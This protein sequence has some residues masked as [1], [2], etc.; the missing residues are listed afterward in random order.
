[1]R[2][3]RPLT[4]LV[5]ALAFFVQA[6]G[7]AYAAPPDGVQPVPY[8][9]SQPVPLPAAPPSPQPPATA[10]A[11]PLSGYSIVG[12]F[13]NPGPTTAVPADAVFLK[14]GGMVRGTLIEMLPNDHVTVQLP[15]G[16]SSVI[17]WGR[18]DHIERATLQVAP[19]GPAPSVPGPRGPR[20]RVAAG[21]T[22]FVHLDADQAIVLESLSDQGGWPH[23]SAVCTAP[24]DAELP[25]RH[26]Y[27]LA[28]GDMRPTRPF[29]LAANPGQ[30]VVLHVSPAS[31]GAFTAGVVLT[32]VGG[33]AIAVGLVVLLFGALGACEQTDVFG[34]C[35]QSQ[36]NTGV[37]TAGA[38]VSL[39][40]VGLL[41]G[42]IILTVTNARSHETQLVSELVRPALARPETAWLRGP[43]WHD[44]V[45]DVSG[46]PK[47]IG[48]PL[49]SGSF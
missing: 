36:A 29:G 41:I 26:E 21:P 32:S 25:L 33:A 2:V 46:T 4:S 48:L 18:I 39:A 27:R 40:G 12:T 31:K 19:T 45:K 22:A 35:L 5:T 16:Q 47:P 24:C 43:L 13:A 37:E 38:I 10:P 8:A 14:D 9:P 23:W 28:G 34:D 6:T 42:G 3:L 11:S 49:F 20:H 1:M 44:S 15:P 7:L 17:E 30:H